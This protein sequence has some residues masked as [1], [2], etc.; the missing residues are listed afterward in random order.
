MQVAEYR[1]RLEEARTA[2][3]SAERDAGREPALA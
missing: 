1:E 3:E 2:V